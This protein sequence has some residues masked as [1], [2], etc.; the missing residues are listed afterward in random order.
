MSLWGPTWPS[1]R[2]SLGSLA[3]R[4]GVWFCKDQKAPN[5]PLPWK[6]D[7]CACGRTCVR[8]RFRETLWISPPNSAGMF[9]E[10]SL[11]RW[12]VACL[13]K[14]VSHDTPDVTPGCTSPPMPVFRTRLPRKTPDVAPCHTSPPQG[15]TLVGEKP[16]VS[17]WSRMFSVS[18]TPGLWRKWDPPAAGCSTFGAA[19][20]GAW[21]H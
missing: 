2:A 18:A 19:W 1:H 3:S 16:T 14:D 6:C 4:W 20:Y 13:F 12:G 15:V 5:V 11:W 7:F 9:T 10:Y 17:P 21:R 8:A